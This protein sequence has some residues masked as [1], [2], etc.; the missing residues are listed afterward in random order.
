MLLL[1]R[2]R[3]VVF[4]ALITNTL[5]ITVQGKVM[6]LMMIRII[7]P[8]TNRTSASISVM[9]EVFVKLAKEKF[10]MSNWKLNSNEL[11]VLEDLFLPDV[12]PPMKSEED[13]CRWQ[14]DPLFS[15]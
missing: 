2:S 12:Y 4:T 15:W 13:K 11:G 14:S 7:E 8:A 1:L 10:A 3:G 5:R 6:V 9:F